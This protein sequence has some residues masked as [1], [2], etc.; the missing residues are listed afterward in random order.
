LT[1]TSNTMEAKIRQGTDPPAIKSCG[2][3]SSLDIATGTGRVTATTEVEGKTTNSTTRSSSGKIAKAAIQTLEGVTNKK[4]REL[5]TTAEAAMVVTTKRDH[6]ITIRIDEIKVKNNSITID[7]IIGKT[8]L[9]KLPKTETPFMIRGAKK[10]TL[11]SE[12]KVGITI[13]TKVLITFST[14]GGT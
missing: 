3:R 5:K 8:M 10:M 7:A 1:T 13:L 4:T 2:L 11:E 9:V 14:A 12:I 6:T